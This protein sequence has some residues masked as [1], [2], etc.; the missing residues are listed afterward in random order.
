VRKSYLKTESV[1]EYSLSTSM[2]LLLPIFLLYLIYFVY[3]LGRLFPI[4]C[5]E[6]K[7]TFK[8]YAQFFEESVYFS[9]LLR[10]LRVSAIVTVVC[11]I[12][13]Y[14]VAHSLAYAKGRRLVI[15]FACIVLPFWTSILVR[16]YAWIVL[17]QRNGLINTLLQ[18]VG[19]VDE[20]LRL[21]YTE[22]AVMVGMIHFLLPLMILP[23]Y[24]VL[25]RIDPNLV[26]AA[27]NLGANPWSTFLRV[28]F[29]LSLPGVG[30]GMS[31][32]FV[33]GLGF[34]ITPAL[35]GGPK[36]LMIST[37]IENQLNINDWPFAAAIAFILLLIT[38]LL[39]MIFNKTIG[40]DKIYRREL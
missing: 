37:L 19:L 38:I 10:T 7:F 24:S 6:P 18:W 15:F 31:I 1:V 8:N 39:M 28:I 35:L 2:V 26:L 22:P 21:L 34:F 29:P 25:K 33:I 20:P 5:F 17:L 16:N 12:V 9:I 13:G 36:N 30:A 32:V 23:I 4:S 11:L 27:Y 40:F 14:P 3:P